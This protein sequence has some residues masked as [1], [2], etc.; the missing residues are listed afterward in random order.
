MELMKEIFRE[1]QA[2][3]KQNKPLRLL[4]YIVVIY[5]VTKGAGLFA[6]KKMIER[7]WTHY[8]ATDLSIGSLSYSLWGRSVF[9]RDIRIADGKTP[10]VEVGQFSVG[11]GLF[12]LLT[13]TPVIRFV[14]INYPTFTYLKK[15]KYSNVAK[16][17]KKKASPS[18][19]T[20]SK[21][22]GGASKPVSFDLKEFN[23][24]GFRMSYMEQF[25]KETFHYVIDDGDIAIQN[26]SYPKL[27]KSSVE[28]SMRFP[29]RAHASFQGVVTPY[30]K[31]EYALKG[32]LK[33]DRA[34]VVAVQS[35]MK[36][37]YGLIPTEGTASL[38]SDIEVQGNNLRS[39]HQ[40]NI[41]KLDLKGD[42]SVGGIAL[43]TTGGI[44][45]QLMKVTNQDTL[46][47]KFDVNGDLSGGK[48]DW[49]MTF[50][51]AVGGAFYAK[52]SDLQRGPAAQIKEATD[53]AIQSI[54]DL[55]P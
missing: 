12:S 36:N 16:L 31:K 26:F 17:F 34:S 22:A 1:F 4:I 8:S 52:I 28:M 49:V 27:K 50:A 45:T 43:G 18:R 54:E 23:V 48:T 38:H 6:V 10:I 19:V 53:K 7:Q 35:F 46:D 33:L 2:L 3:F 11:V 37:H 21:A 15:E 5:F 42:D 25:N 55:I 41:Y 32:K 24:E 30:A 14:N 9:V 13:H 20:A 39:S 47:L 29:K 44:F 51:E 40:L